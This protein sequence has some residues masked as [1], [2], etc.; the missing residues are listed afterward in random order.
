MELFVACLCV[1]LGSLHVSLDLG[2]VLSLVTELRIDVLRDSVD[3]NQQGDHIVDRLFALLDQVLHLIHR[4]PLVNAT[5]PLEV[6]VWVTYSSTWK[7]SYELGA[8]VYDLSGFIS[9]SAPP[10]CCTPAVL[11]Q[12]KLSGGVT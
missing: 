5:T 8:G 6:F 10:L 3:V 9:M 1:S 11:K 12:T 4:C 7:T 2:E